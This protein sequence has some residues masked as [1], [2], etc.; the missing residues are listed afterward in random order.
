MKRSRRL[1]ARGMKRLLVAGMLAVIPA[2]S[3]TG[4]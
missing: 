4:G 3:L 1:R 2:G